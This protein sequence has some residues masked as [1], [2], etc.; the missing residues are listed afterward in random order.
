MYSPFPF[1]SAFKKR[2]NKSSCF[3][4][5]GLAVS[6]QR[7]DTGLIPGP[8]QWVKG[9]GVATAAVKVATEAQI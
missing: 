5:M 9:S 4:A 8:A 6:L 2:I 7:Q 3:D 1:T